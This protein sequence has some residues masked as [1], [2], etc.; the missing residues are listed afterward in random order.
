[1][2]KKVFG[3]LKVFSKVLGTPTPKKG[4]D[5]TRKLVSL[6]GEGLKAP[7]E[8]GLWRLVAAFGVC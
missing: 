3:K 7:G 4:L 5:N 1:M 6:K 2:L 8:S